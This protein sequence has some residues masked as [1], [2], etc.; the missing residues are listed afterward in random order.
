MA[1]LPLRIVANRCPVL[2]KKAFV[3]FA[4][5]DVNVEAVWLAF[6]SNNAAFDCVQQVNV[7]KESLP[8]KALSVWFP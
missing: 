4:L 2:R 7:C 8:I 6:K 5:A 1:E 3:F